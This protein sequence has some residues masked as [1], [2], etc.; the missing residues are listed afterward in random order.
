MNSSRIRSGLLSQRAGSGARLVLAVSLGL[1]SVVLT[2][3][4]GH[5][6]RLTPDQ[7]ITRFRA[8]D[9]AKTFDVAQ[10]ERS[11]DLARMLVVRVGDGWWEAKSEDRVRVAEKWLHMWRDAVPGGIVAV[12]D[13]S[14]RPVLNYDGNGKARL[15]PRPASVS[16]LPDA[17]QEQRLKSADEQSAASGG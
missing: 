1:A 16:A 3:L 6:H 11:A 17:E 9:M 14:D 12:V 10:V 15:E 13:P 7:V 4:P 8:A 5:S 2:P